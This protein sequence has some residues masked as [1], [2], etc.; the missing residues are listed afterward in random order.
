MNLR[1]KMQ[2]EQQLKELFKQAQGYAFDYADE[3]LQR[4][5]FPAEQ[6]LKR[7]G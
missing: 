1:E 4:N 7:S 5:V 6:A 2:R 3:A